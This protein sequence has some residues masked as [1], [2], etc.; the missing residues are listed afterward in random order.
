MFFRHTESG[1]VN[2]IEQAS[3]GLY[4][5]AHKT[6]HLVMSFSLCVGIHLLDGSILQSTFV[7]MVLV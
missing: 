5:Q 6:E 1:D 3:N 7:H 2:W 4:H